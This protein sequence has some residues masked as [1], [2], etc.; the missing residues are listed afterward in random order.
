MTVGAILGQSAPGSS[1]ATSGVTSRAG[2]PCVPAIERKTKFVVVDLGALEATSL[3]VT[4]RA[5]LDRRRDGVVWHVAVGAVAWRRATTHLGV[6]VAIHARLVDV[7]ALEL[8]LRVLG[9]L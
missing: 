3:G 8:Q 1:L 9:V 6:L 5:I 7:F 4:L 2:R